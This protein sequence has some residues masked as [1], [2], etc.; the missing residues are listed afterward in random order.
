MLDA[1]RAEVAA[2][3]LLTIG[4][5]LPYWRLL[6]FSAVYVTD[7]L[8]T[9]DIFNGE[10]AGRA[11]IGDLM[12]A[13]QPPLWTS[14]LCS[15]IPLTGSLGE[16]I[17]LVLFWLLPPAAAL[18]LL[19]LVLLMVASHGAYDLARRC[20]AGLPGAVLAG[21]AFAGS[22]YFA[23]QLRHVSILATV[24]WLPVGL[25]VIDRAL[26]PTGSSEVARRLFFIA[27]FGLVFAEQVLAGFPQSAY[28]CALV[29]GAFALVRALGNYDRVK[30]FSL[31]PFLLAGLAVAVALA[32][33]VG[34][35]VLLPLSE[36]GATSDRSASLGWRW[37]SR[38]VY[39]PWNAL[40]FVVP[41]INGD[42]SD[43]TYR[44]PSIF[45]EDYGYVGL[46]T[47]LLAIYGAVRCWRRRLVLFFTATTIAAYL[48]VLGRT[49]IAYF[50]AYA[51]L[52]G[53]D[54]FR[55][56]T[57]FL[58]VV[59]L[60]LSVLAAIG[61][62]RLTADLDRRFATTWP[63]LASSVAVLVC[64]GTSVDLW[65]HQSR[66]N[67]MVPASVWLAPPSS[68][69]AIRTDALHPRTYTPNHFQQHVQ[70]FVQASGWTRLDPYFHLRDVLQPN[71][72][73]GY[74]NLP[75]ADCYAGLA[76]RWYVDVWGDHNRRG[77]VAP[78]L[79]RV[80]PKDQTFHVRP[81]FS[82]VMGAYGVSHVLS[83][84]PAEGAPL[85]LVHHAGHAF[86]YRVEGAARVRFVPAA[87]HV[88]SNQEAAARMLD[89][90]FDPDREVL[91]HDA[92][93][94]VA[95]TAD[96]SRVVMTS[97]PVITREDSRHVV[98]DVEAPVAGFLVLADTFF[99]GWSAEV[100]GRPAPIIRANI[101]VRA[102][103]LPRGRHVVRFVYDAPA[104]FGG[105]KITSIAI[106][107]LSIWIGGAAYSWRRT[108]PAR[109]H[110]S[111]GS[112]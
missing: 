110:V 43:N 64:A 107:G 39:W 31:S 24:A 45:W 84:Y 105:L 47:F 20:G 71:L 106:V 27:V 92:A 72:G 6:T 33:A 88:S 23:A 83:P 19:M 17:G 90:S 48:M 104:F 3:A 85:P 68:V 58:V 21:L 5:L 51:L 15:G 101:S 7:D 86:I 80:S 56:P 22:G 18:N 75:S 59:E 29:Y 96:D 12:R 100:D 65:W 95:S 76:P 99:P 102:I 11:L 112:A 9:S 98:I 37:A 41:Y 87:R 103:Q 2:R 74:W 46:A 13:G 89:G 1:R 35:V 50:L 42:V 79:A 38:A 60:G 97:R 54:L 67:P 63:R 32:L 28:I 66:Q 40:T 34:A 4:A 49:T 55:L 53:M 57:R 109:L 10:L 26:A 36:L 73:G 62:T 70:A 25:A 30:R 82:R 94:T 61:L 16:P 14:A 93:R 111:R 78:Q 81:Q 52:P 77:L 91:L 44:G 8:F 108:R 69:S